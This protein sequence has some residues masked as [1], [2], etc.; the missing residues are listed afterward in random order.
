MVNI[1][2]NIDEKSLNNRWNVVWDENSSFITLEKLATHYVE[3]IKIHMVHFRDR[4][5][6]VENVK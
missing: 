2:L 3:H 4:L 1:I 5:N 6:E